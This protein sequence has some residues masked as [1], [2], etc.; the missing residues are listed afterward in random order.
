MCYHACINVKGIKM[1][2]KD[3]AIKI[4]EDGLGITVSPERLISNIDAPKWYKEEMYRKA[5][6]LGNKG[7]V[8]W[9]GD[10]IKGFRPDQPMESISFTI[11]ID[12]DE[13]EKLKLTDSDME[14][15]NND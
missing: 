11:T 13:L 14:N 2:E 3:S 10:M 1:T 6:N 4:S 15:A 8:I 5:C 9:E 7:T 12:G